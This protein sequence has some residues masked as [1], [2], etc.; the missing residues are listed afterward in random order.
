MQVNTIEEKKEEYRNELLEFTQDIEFVQSLSNPSYLSYLIEKGYLEDKQFLNYLKYL[1]YLKTPEFIKFII[2]P[3][4]IAC[5]ELLQLESFRN[6]LLTNPDFI[7]YLL[8]LS[9]MEWFNL[10]EEEIKKT[11]QL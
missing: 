11:S 6:E 1:N 8:Y 2:Y 5:L 7:N 4:G 3:R 10:K 9:E